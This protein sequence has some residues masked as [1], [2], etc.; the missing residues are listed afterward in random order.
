MP[1]PSDHDLLVEINTQ[2]RRI[3]VL[4]DG[5]DGKPGFI[6]DVHVLKED[7]RRRELEAQ[8][9]RDAVPTVKQETLV[10]ARWSSGVIAT[11]VTGIVLGIMKALGG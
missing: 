8:E 1:A 4:L 10:N 3:L 5:G 9:L 6:N 2:M 11:I 7:M